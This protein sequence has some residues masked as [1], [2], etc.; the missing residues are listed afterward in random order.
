MSKKLGIAVVLSVAV[1]GLAGLGAWGA[2]RFV[3]GPAPTN[4]RTSSGPNDKNSTPPTSDPPDSLESRFAS[5]V[6]PFLERNCFGCHGPKKQEGE[7]DLSRYTSM[8]AVSKDSRHWD[9]VLKRLQAEEMPPEK[10]PHQPAPAERAAVIA[11]IRDL[12]DHEAQR[13]AGDG[14]RDADEGGFHSGLG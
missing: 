11:W 6:Q 9:L 7:L 3:V 5:R 2:W 8:S 1:L 4:S 13:N 14:P 10:A 12:R